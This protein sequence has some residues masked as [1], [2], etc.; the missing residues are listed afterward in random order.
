MPQSSVQ[1]TKKQLASGL[2]KPLNATCII[3]TISLQLGLIFIQKITCFMMGEIMRKI[4]TAL[5][6]IGVA[7][8]LAGA[9]NVSADANTQTATTKADV[10]FGSGSLA[11]TN[12]TSEV[13]FGTV[14]ISDLYTKDITE[15]GHDISA[16]VADYLGTGNGWTLSVKRTAWT[17]AVDTAATAMNAN[18]KLSTN[19]IT[20]IT[21]TDTT[22]ATGDEGQQTVADKL[23]LTIPQATNVRA[24]TYSANVIWTLGETPSA[25]VE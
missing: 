12:T 21:T 5:L 7:A 11:L 25:T 22:I 4:I 9:V 18:A 24:D 19:E 17:G 16:T 2:K 6:G 13:G 1:I 20:D 8:S 15:A 23:G 14:A 10:T 3:S